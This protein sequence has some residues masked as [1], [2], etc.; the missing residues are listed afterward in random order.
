MGQTG[1]RMIDPEG[2]STMPK[3]ARPA[4]PGLRRRFRL[5]VLVLAVLATLVR[6]AMVGS[7]PRATR[8]ARSGIGGAPARSAD[9]ARPAGEAPRHPGP[10]ALPPGPPTPPPACAVGANLVPTCHVLWG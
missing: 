3:H 10:A 1:R 9:P 7:D 4:P 5:A 2:L 6:A 8:P